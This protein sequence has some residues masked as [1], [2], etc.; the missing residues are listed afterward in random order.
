[1]TKILVT[2]SAG[3]IGFS[4]CIKLLERGNSI[5]GIDNHNDYYDP[6]IKEAR[7]K[8]LLA[9]PNNE[10]HILDLIDQKNLGDIPTLL[11]IT[12]SAGLDPNLAEQALENRAFADQVNRDWEF[13]RENGITGVPTFHAK[14]FFLYGS[15]PFEVLERFYNN[16]K[17][18]G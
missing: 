4:L 1:M 12:R 2:D 14:N 13:A 10:H 7:V 16:L 11:E 6:K 17:K 9:Y 15:Q 5:I 18:K 8:R 3:F